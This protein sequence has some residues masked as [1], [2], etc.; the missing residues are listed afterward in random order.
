MEYLVFYQDKI[1]RYA[2]ML[3]NN[4]GYTDHIKLNRDTLAICSSAIDI[5]LTNGK[6]D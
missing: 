5:C 2:K 3:F 1:I 6:F 4:L